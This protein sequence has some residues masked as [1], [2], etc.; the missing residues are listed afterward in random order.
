MKIKIIT[1]F[2]MLFLA[3]TIATADEGRLRWLYA[4]VGKV[5]EG[6]KIGHFVLMG[7]L[8]WLLNTSLGWRR[9]SVM[10]SAVWLGSVMVFTF[11]TLEECSQRFFP[12]RTFEL[13]DLAGDY[14]GIAMAGLFAPC[15][16]TIR[17]G[18]AA[19]LRR[20]RCARVCG[21]LP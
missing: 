18:V 13:L 19:R 1:F 6:D 10:G 11:A 7:M 17:T 9:S 21:E 12:A 15:A 4:V 8:A 20:A 5:P 2:Y 3:A 16:D 14:S